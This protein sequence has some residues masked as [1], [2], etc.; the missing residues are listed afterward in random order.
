SRHPNLKQVMSMLN[1]AFKTNQA[2]N[3]LIFHTDRGWQYQ[4]KAYQHEL[5]IRGIETKQSRKGC[6]PNDGLMEGFFGILK[7]EMFYG[8][9]NKYDSLD[10]L[11]QAIRKY[12]NDCN[13]ERTKD[14]LKELAPIEYRNK[15]LTA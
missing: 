5:A 3:G 14:K 12:I 11:E 6:S 8:Q 7:R 9:E 10:E 2:L 4:H 1:D 13:T 15:S